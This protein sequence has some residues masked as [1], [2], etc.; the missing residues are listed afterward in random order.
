MQEDK[1]MH[2]IE[3]AKSFYEE[4]A[5]EVIDL[6]K[7]KL[8]ANKATGNVERSMRY[9]IYE[10]KGRV[11]M[12][13]LGDESAAFATGGRK[14]GSYGNID[15]IQ[16]WIGVKG[17]KPDK[18]TE[19]QFAFLIARKQQKFGRRRIKFRKP[20]TTFINKKIENELPALIEKALS[21]DIAELARE[22]LNGK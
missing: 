6:V 9:E 1:A 11:G 19:K 4:K 17:I 2:A 20:V 3:A 22:Q 8:R 5:S 13:I 14:K 16:K 18:I 12:R 7:K 21:T 10:D 15:D